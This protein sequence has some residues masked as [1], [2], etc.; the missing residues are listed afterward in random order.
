MNMN[1]PITQAIVWPS[2]IVL[3]LLI[4]HYLT[5]THEGMPVSRLSRL[6][7]RYVVRVDLA[8]DLADDGQA[9]AGI[10]S[11]AKVNPERAETLHQEGESASGIITLSEI[12]RIEAQTLARLI[13]AG[14]VGVTDAVKIG[15][16]AKSGDKYSQKTRILQQE[17]AQQ[18]ER[19]PTMS[20]EQKDVRAKLQL[21]D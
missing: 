11:A 15:M 10:V 1:D 8:D 7:S 18:K 14:K 9:S 3:A 19:Y 4:A 16:R 20:A 6:V 17:V 2:L 5:E 13:I 12:E 21:D